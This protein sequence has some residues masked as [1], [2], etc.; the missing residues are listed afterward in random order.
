[1]NYKKTCKIHFAYAIIKIYGRNKT[2]KTQKNTPPDI[3]SVVGY[4]NNR[5]VNHYHHWS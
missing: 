4:R 2:R 5:R 3:R 1:M